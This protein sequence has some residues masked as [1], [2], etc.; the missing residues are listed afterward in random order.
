MTVFEILGFFLAS[1]M[2]LILGLLGAGGAMLTLPILVY[3]FKLTPYIATS[4]SLLIVGCTA[5]VGAFRYSKMDLID[6][7]AF[8]LFILPSMITVLFSRLYLLPRIPHPDFFITLFFGGLLLTS[9]YFMFYPP[10]TPEKPYSR[11]TLLIFSALIGIVTGLAGIGGGFLIVPTLTLAFHLPMKKAVGTSL[12]IM[13]INS[14]T[15]FTEDWISGIHIQWDFVAVYLFIALIGMG[16][17]MR[18]SPSIPSRK[19]SHAFAI[20]TACIGCLMILYPF[21]L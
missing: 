19:L 7:H 5:L 21:T 17:G 13:T 6:W 14:L 15:G 3:C 2:G 11:W 1:V 12:A 18:L 4:Y 10:K 8:S 20:L 16:I 9:S